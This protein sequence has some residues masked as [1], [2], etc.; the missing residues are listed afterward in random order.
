[1][2]KSFLVLFAF[3]FWYL[4]MAC[5]STQ[6]Q[7][8]FYEPKHPKYSIEVDN[9]GRKHGK[10]IWW[11]ANGTIK[12]EAINKAGTRDGLFTSWYE[13]G[14][15]WYEG[16]EYHG[17]PESTLTYWHPN[18]KI[19]SQALF[20]DGIQLERKDFDEEGN[21]LGSRG[22]VPKPNF[23]TLEVDDQAG[24]QA[25]RMRKAGLQMWALRVRKT[26]EGF[27]VLPKEFE[28]QRPYRS[29]AK[30]KVSREG[31]ILGVTWI[32]K[33]P[34]SAFN[35]LAQQTFKRIKRLPAFPGMITEP[36]LE[37][38][39]EFISLGKQAPRRRLEIR[40]SME[41]KSTRP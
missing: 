21:V 19:K 18:G 32:E 27:W 7:T 22:L 31:K 28:K 12:Y 34:S 5:S 40:D 1:M 10:E 25:E 3:S 4:L 26:V 39:Y 20:R 8:G 17:K 9:E 41:V 14:K 11:Y 24:S 38:Q 35:T 2:I 29:V 15:K 37:V 33:S 13:D 30:I 23:P 16:Y 6:V 36:V